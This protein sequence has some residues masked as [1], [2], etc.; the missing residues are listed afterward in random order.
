VTAGDDERER[1]WK[2]REGD[3]KRGRE[4]WEQG[5]RVRVRVVICDFSHW[6]T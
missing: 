2:K 5:K 1:R 6:A 3:G 4:G